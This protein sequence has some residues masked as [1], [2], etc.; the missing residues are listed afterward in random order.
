MIKVTF[1]NS[2]WVKIENQKITASYGIPKKELQTLLQG[3][4]NLD[5]PSIPN[6]DM[7]CARHV[8]EVLGDGKIE[9]F[10]PKKKELVPPG[11]I[12]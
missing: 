11:T 6:P 12:I 5:S 8:A 7:I 2:A 1:P 9:D 10:S 3:V 4:G